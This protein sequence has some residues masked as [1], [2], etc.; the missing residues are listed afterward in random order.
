MLFALPDE[1]KAKAAHPPRPN[2]NRGF[3][4]VGQETLSKVKDYEKGNREGI[5][6]YD[7]KVA[8]T[9]AN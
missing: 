7:V 5:A 1:V 3:T 2:P 6:V 9:P 4:Y 8:Y